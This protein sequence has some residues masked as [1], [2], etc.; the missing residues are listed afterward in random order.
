MTEVPIRPFALP[1]TASVGDEDVLTIDGAAGLR[2]MRH[3]DYRSV[4]VGGIT[5]AIVY[6]GL[7]HGANVPNTSTSVGDFY[8]IDLAGTS[9]GK[10]WQP[11]DMAVYRGSGVW[12]RVRLALDRGIDVRLFGAVC[13]GVTDDTIA[14]QAAY[15]ALPATGGA[16]FIPGQSKFNLTITK[17]NVMIVGD[18]HVKNYVNPATTGQFIPADITKPLIQVGNDTAYVRG[19]CMQNVTLNGVNGSDYGDIGI[20][21]AGG[22]F[23]CH[24][25]NVTVWNFKTCFK[26]QGGASYACSK[27]HVRGF[28]CQPANI[29]DA[30]GIHAI[31]RTNQASYTTAIYFASGNVDGPGAAGSYAVEVD[32]TFMSFAQV[33]MDLV[34]GHGVKFSA[35]NVGV[36]SPYIVCSDLTLDS[37][38]STDVLAEGNLNVRQWSWW[39]RGNCSADGKLKIQN[40]DLVLPVA[41]HLIPYQSQANYLQVVGEIAFDKSGTVDEYDNT[42]RMFSDGSLWAVNDNGLVQLKGST[43][44]KI[45]PVGGSVEILGGVGGAL[46]VTAGNVQLDNGKAILMKDNGGVAR[47]VLQ[48]T[49]ASGDVTLQAQGTLNLVGATGN[50]NVNAVG[51]ILTLGASASFTIVAGDVYLDNTR[52]I[53]FKDSGGEPQ[54]ALHPSGDDLLVQFKRHVVL[55]STGGLPRA[56]NLTKTQRNAITGLQGGEF[57]YQTTNTPGMRFYVAGQWVDMAGNPDP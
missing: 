12:D 16:I 17:S 3:A 23:E 5:G 11:F 56:V 10:T 22:A 46:I 27:I 32:G 57:C 25:T 55:G 31:M 30:R 4:L 15:D 45:D 37:D 49:A 14:V 35:T 29:A 53:L 19:F 26:F 41:G 13:D 8:V 21:L 18:A 28:N 6:R 20:Y 38:N 50:V 2:K 44:V 36:I 24:L 47:T 48:A 33:Y 51:M 34:D 43:G 40:G 39:F 42:Q 9:Q 7:V 54:Y 52:G 1:G